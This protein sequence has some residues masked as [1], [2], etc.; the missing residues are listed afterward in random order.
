MC[1]VKTTNGLYEKGRAL[2]ENG[3]FISNAGKSNIIGIGELLPSPEISFELINEKG[4]YVISL[5]KCKRVQR[6]RERKH[7]HLFEY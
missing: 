1:K 6:F 4:G 2:G 5:F 7:W 3:Q